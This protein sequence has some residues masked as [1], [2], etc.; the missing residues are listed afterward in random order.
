MNI[1][2]KI[3][4]AAH[5][6]T[7]YRIGLLQAKAYRILK[8]RTTLVLAPFGISTIE[9]ALLGLL[10]DTKGLRMKQLAD[11]LGVEAPFVTTM[12]QQLQ[13]KLLVHLELNELDKR[14]KTLALTNEGKRFVTET[15]PQVRSAMRPI[16]QGAGVTDLLGYVSIL[17][18][19]IAND[20]K[21]D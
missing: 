10:A 19:I 14:V 20:S 2:T 6:R 13:K 3:K 9:W 8:Q 21:I 12:V 17:E 5:N 11:E 15:E 4:S 1:L 7:S 16:I 18:L